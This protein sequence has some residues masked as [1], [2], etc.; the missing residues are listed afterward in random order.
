MLS[1]IKQAESSENSHALHS[2]QQTSHGEAQSCELVS[3]IK[4]VPV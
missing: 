1:A 3:T 2:Q 4:N